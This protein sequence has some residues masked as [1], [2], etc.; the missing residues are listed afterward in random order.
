M[1]VKY[2]CQRCRLWVNG[3]ICPYCSCITFYLPHDEEKDYEDEE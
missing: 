1:W 2:W 3:Q